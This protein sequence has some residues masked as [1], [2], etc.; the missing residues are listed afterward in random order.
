MRIHLLYLTA[1]IAGFCMMALEI[2]GGRYLYPRFGSSIDVWAAIISVFI[3]SLSIGYWLGGRIADRANTNAPLGWIILAAGAYYLLLPTFARPFIEALP[4]TIYTAR[5]GS[6][7][8]A[9]VLFLPPSLLLG[10]VSPMLVKLVFT[11]AER[12]G[13]TT[14][15]L[16][17]VSA[18]GNVFGILVTDYLLL[19]AFSLNANTL[20]MGLVL[21]LT[22]LAHVLR[23]I[24]SGIAAP[25]PEVLTHGAPAP[26]VAT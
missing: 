17:A 16:Y 5:W 26:R 8:A 13:R 10:C 7:V 18:C 20:G 21:G 22:G 23:R 2:M 19:A 3:L 14:G 11:A 4:S 24:E 1:V 12:V 6:L 15:T 25:E 9:T